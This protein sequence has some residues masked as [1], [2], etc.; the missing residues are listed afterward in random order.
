[1]SYFL[2]T[3]EDVLA[4]HAELVARLVRREEE[5]TEAAV[6]MHWADFPELGFS[7]LAIATRDR[8]GLFS[9]ITGVLAAE[10]INI[11]AAR[12]ATSSDG[13]ALDAFRISRPSDTATLDEERAERLEGTLRDVLHGTVDVEQ[14]VARSARPWL[15]R[16]RRPVATTIE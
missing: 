3:P 2:S 5:G 16:P 10:G 11:L 13:V 8:P 7:E 12:M 15:R 14:L 9:M 4:D 1:D 6:A